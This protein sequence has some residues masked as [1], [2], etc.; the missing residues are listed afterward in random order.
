[1]CPPP[2]YGSDSIRNTPL[3]LHWCI[4]HPAEQSPTHFRPTRSP[5]E[6]SAGT[7]SF[8]LLL[9]AGPATMMSGQPVDATPPPHSAQ[10]AEWTSRLAC[11]R[12][13][14][15]DGVPPG[16]VLFGDMHRGWDWKWS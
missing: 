10:L 2:G 13:T 12:C 1:M 9:G 4:H 14:L 11:W 15:Q 3:K 5:A 6:L 7:A 8:S 16:G